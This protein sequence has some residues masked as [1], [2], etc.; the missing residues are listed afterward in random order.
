MHSSYLD[1]SPDVDKR[2]PLE[3]EEPQCDGGVCGSKPGGKIDKRM[4]DLGATYLA[5][6][7]ICFSVFPLV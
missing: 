7:F 3:P 6:V 4:I 1:Y 5:S 2:E